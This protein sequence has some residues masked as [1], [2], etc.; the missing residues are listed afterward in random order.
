MLRLTNYDKQISLLATLFFL[1]GW[2]ERLCVP[3]FETN[4]TRIDRDAGHL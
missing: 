4:T 2:T 3:N 1:G